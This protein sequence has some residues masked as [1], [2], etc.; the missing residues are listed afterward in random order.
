MVTL[1]AVVAWLIIQVAE[2]LESLVGLPEWA[3]STVLALLAI[4]FP[5]ALIFS[6]FY[7][8]TPEGISL[9]K[10]VDRA[11]SMTQVTGRRLDFI[12]IS[13]LCAAVILFAYDKWWTGRPPEK[14]I[15]VLAFENMSGDPDQEFFSD[16]ISEDILNLL[17]SLPEL[18][19]ISRSSSFS[20]KG[21]DIDIPTVAEQLNVAHVLEGS[22]R[23]VGNQVRI[24][25]QLIDASSDSHLWSQSYDRELDDI[26]AVQDEIAGAI[27]NALKVELALV[28]GEVV[29]PTVIKAANTDAYDAYLQGRELFRQ[30]GTD[31]VEAAIRHFE[32]SLRLDDSFAPA[33]AQLAI[34][35]TMLGR[36]GVY[37]FD[38]A[39]RIA[40]PHLDRAQALAPDLAEAHGGRAL[41][42]GFSG[43]PQ[44]E[45]EHARKALASNPSYSDA[46]NWLSIALGT[47]GRYE[48]SDAVLERML[49]I[50]PLTLVGRYNYIEGLGEKG[51]VEE[52]HEMSD[53]LLVQDP[54][55]GYNTHA[56]ISIVF[57]G[58]L[59]E[60]L[61]WALKM[62]GGNGVIMFVFNLVGEYDEARRMDER[63]TFW[64]DVYER[65]WDEA[66][67]A[68]QRNLARHTDNESMIEDAALVLY[69]ARRIDEALPL[70]ERLLG[71]VPEGRPVPGFRP[72]SRTMELALA[73]RNAGD[74]EGARAA[75]QIARQDHAARQK[76]GRNNV[77]HSPHSTRP[78]DMDFGTYR[79][80][81]IQ[82]LKI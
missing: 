52:A 13:L 59:A 33:H 8:I 61:Y 55:F 31:N 11:E 37:S 1:Y 32:R 25:A 18:K 36:Y 14:S 46:M 48:E 77:K 56:V 72:L 27:S 16:G 38:E 78:Y 20:F 76:A 7:E 82:S 80:L 74:E 30:R 65:N 58:N 10:D 45:V 54:R 19:V 42:A 50:D 47:L 64:V 51:R 6:W 68:T 15:A 60:G 26:F 49:V 40:I 44:A 5:I 24:T 34:A 70:Y 3:G 63:Q 35:T 39:R 4:G 75:A 69:L 29:H 53:E 57:E 17:A 28:A 21:K 81:M 71:F 66:I 22:V 2:V 9:E 67:R 12:V 41:L 79:F 73:R 62:G 23:R 43:D